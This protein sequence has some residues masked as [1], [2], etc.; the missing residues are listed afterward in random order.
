MRSALL[1]LSLTFAF[2]AIAQHAHSGSVHSTAGPQETGQ[3]GFAALS[4]IVT[5]LRNDPQTDWSTVDIAALRRHLVE[6]DLLTSEAEVVV[7]HRPEGARF[8]IRGTQRAVEAVRAMVP[9]HAPFLAAE[10]DWNVSTEET[11]NG[12]ALIVDG[13]AVRIQALGFFGMMTIGAHHQEHHLMLAKGS[14]PHR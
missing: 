10:T 1:V 5:I 3:S 8:E 6:M 13:D 9:A 14:A 7:T 11:D 12:V 2:P 4:E